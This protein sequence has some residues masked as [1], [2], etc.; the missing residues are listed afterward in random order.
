MTH[1]QTVFQHWQLPMTNAFW[2]ASISQDCNDWLNVQR[3]Q[4]KNLK[5]IFQNKNFFLSVHL[6]KSHATTRRNKKIRFIS[7]RTIFDRGSNFTFF[8]QT[9]FHWDPQRN[10]FLSSM[11]S[12]SVQFEKKKTGYF[13]GKR[14][15]KKKKKSFREQCSQQCTKTLSTKSLTFLCTFLCTISE[16]VKTNQIWIVIPLFRLIWHKKTQ[17]IFDKLRNWFAEC[18]YWIDAR[19]LFDLKRIWSSWLFPFDYEPNR[20]LIDS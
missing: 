4:N 16:F 6:I 14:K 1:L 17:S 5:R 8:N 3:Y 9:E 7:K 2:N 18:E 19:F 20:I 12:H 15:E 11:Q 13:E 10:N